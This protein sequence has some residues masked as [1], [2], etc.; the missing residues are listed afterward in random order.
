[1]L[2]G[3]FVKI[4]LKSRRGNHL[5][6]AKSSFLLKQSTM[7]YLFLFLF[8]FASC[9]VK[10]NT[11]GTDEKQEKPVRKKGKIRNGI[12]V[13][14]SG[15]LKVEQAF[16][17]YEDS[18]NFVQEDNLT[19]LNKPVK[20]HLVVKGWKPKNGKVYLDA[21]QKIVTNEGDLLLH[22]K[23][24]LKEMG[25]IDPQDAQYLNF[26]F[27]ITRLEKL[28]DYFLVEVMARNEAY[29]QQVKASFKI[30]IE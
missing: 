27:V 25:G 5:C 2:S 23:N 16:L 14:S 12:E 6:N 3:L 30:H 10:V 19:T 28:F 18:G 8:L 9:E 24:M 4:L 29:D 22:E 13:Q 20:I 21:E 1:M 17:T 26:R 11:N 7:R 15:G